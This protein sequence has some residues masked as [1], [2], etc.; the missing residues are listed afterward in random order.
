MCDTKLN[1]HV[2]KVT[3]VTHGFPINEKL[4]KTLKL[5]PPYIL[6]FF[7]FDKRGFV[8]VSRYH[9]RLCCD[10]IICF[11]IIINLL[12]QSIMILKRR[13]I[14]IKLKVKKLFLYIF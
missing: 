1:A 7:F 2:L 9:H 3:K 12:R 8:A 14:K 11:R 5:K 13:K 10:K 6:L 4:V